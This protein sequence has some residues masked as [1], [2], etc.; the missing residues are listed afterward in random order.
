MASQGVSLGVDRVV[1]GAIAGGGL[2][3]GAIL[4]WSGIWV[5]APS[6]TI[7]GAVAF[8][9][10]IAASVG[11]WRGSRKSLRLLTAVPL[12]I[13]LLAPFVDAG[14]A[15]AL[16]SILVAVLG[17]GML[18]AE[19]RRQMW[20][21][22]T[23]VLGAALV[24]PTLTTLNIF[25]DAPVAIPAGRVATTTIVGTA[26]VALTAVYLELRAVLIRRE[27]HHA[28]LNQFIS[29]VAHSLRTPLTAVLG[30]GNILAEEIR[31]EPLAE[32]AQVVCFRAWELSD[33][34]EDL[35]VLAR[36]DAAGLEVQHRPV[37]VT[38]VIDRILDELPSA[39]DKLAYAD[40]HGVVLGDPSRVRQV[41]RHLLA[42]AVT[43]G[44]PTMWIFTRH[45][46][47]TT[48]IRV[49]D[50]GDPIP[51]EDLERFFEP[52]ETG[53]CNSGTPSRGIGLTVARLLARQMGG[54]VTLTSH[55]DGTVAELRLP[56]D[57]SVP[58]PSRTGILLHRSR[59]V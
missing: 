48:I 13:A 51:P 17:T 21:F 55:H 43:H 56:T 38:P 3:M 39:R 31:D 29:A 15:L 22:V 18:L 42:N 14:M 41:L 7:V 19:T 35:V 59:R 2:S 23:L 49:Q 1:I 33:G 25:P 47:T 50:D 27:Q 37:Q 32:F 4:L 34:I 10:G 26:L 6:A 24:D 54:D 16:N 5:H 45:T 12:L 8:G 9:V 36:S 11:T 46:W 30:F 53:H 44:G 52:F 58:D 40:V 57:T 20:G 28:E